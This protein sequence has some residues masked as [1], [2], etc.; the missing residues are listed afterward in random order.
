[1]GFDKTREVDLSNNAEI[2]NLSDALDQDEMRDKGV[3]E[4]KIERMKP[5]RR[6]D[7]FLIY[8][9]NKYKETWDFFIPIILVVT[10]LQ[11]PL[12]LA[13]DLKDL[14]S[15]I[16]LYVIDFAFLIDIFLTFNS[17]YIKDEVEVIEDRGDI[18]CN[19]I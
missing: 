2:F 13:F 10:C 12:V 18:A 17:C 9:E 11:T 19:Y 3:C 15:R 7:T 14:G 4:S 6:S 16:T 1:M 5:K 8:P